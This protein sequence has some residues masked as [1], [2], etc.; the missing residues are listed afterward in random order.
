MTATPLDPLWTNRCGPQL[1]KPQHN[2][3]FIHTACREG[4][5]SFSALVRHHLQISVPEMPNAPP[6]GTL[7]ID[8]R[9]MPEVALAY[10]LA[11][12]ESQ[13]LAQR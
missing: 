4:S 1:P 12:L 6:A 10:F 13:C 7:Q 9:T 5:N 3:A 8:L 11:N 2:D